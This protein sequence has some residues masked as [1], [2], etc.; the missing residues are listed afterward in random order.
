[1]QNQLRIFI[2]TILLFSTFLASHRL[3][4]GAENLD[5][6]GYLMLDSDYFDGS[7]LEESDES[8]SE[9]YI[10]RARLSFKSKIDDNWQGKLQLGFA[11]EEAEIKD[12]YL[13]YNG[14]SWTDLTIG[15][16]KEGFGLEKLTSSRNLLMIERSMMTQ[17]F[18]PGRSVGVSLSGELQSTHWQLGYYQP[19]DEESTSAVT[20]RFAWLPWRENDNLLHLGLAF[21]ERDYDGNE[22]RINEK[23][24]VYSSD[25]LFE[26]DTILADKVS[27][28]GVEILWIKDQFTVMSEWQ[29]ASVFDGQNESY[30]YKGKYL[31]LSYQ[32]SGGHR[33]YKKGLLARSPNKGWELTTRYSDLSLFEEDE[34]AETY[35]VGLNYSVNEQLKFMADIIKSEQ[36]ESGERVDSGTAISLR[37]QYSF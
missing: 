29:Q 28:K 22:F 21:S 16:Q 32:L 25:S 37:V 34:K 36:F 3:V 18:A 5:V 6:S 10:R 14:W 11:D 17:A 12:A 9:S 8:K 2:L 23:L 1:M 4:K 20:G 33:K 30:D 19:S 24:E 15:Q 27:L 13:R 31:Q 35:A 26:G 7:L